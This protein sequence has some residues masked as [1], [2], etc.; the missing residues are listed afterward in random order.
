MLHKRLS[1][2]WLITP[3][4]ARLYITFVCIHILLSSNVCSSSDGLEAGFLFYIVF[5]DLSEGTTLTVLSWIYKKLLL[6][7]INKYGFFYPLWQ[8]VF[9]YL[10]IIC[11]LIFIDFQLFCQILPFNILL[12]YYNILFVLQYCA[13]YLFFLLQGCVSGFLR[14][15]KGMLLLGSLLWSICPQLLFLL[16]RVKSFLILLLILRTEIRWWWMNTRTRMK[17]F[18]SPRLNKRFDM[19]SGF[20]LLCFLYIKE[21]I[22][23]SFS[24]FCRHTR[25]GFRVISRK[26]VNN[27][28]LSLILMVFILV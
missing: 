21:Y 28:Y 15:M 1:L 13:Y 26:Q 23:C 6:Q 11:Y 14:R 24:F 10:L 27:D 16:A 25:M 19:N 22:L 12:E 17:N 3:Y 8:N 4:V 7:Y 18:R 20:V 5:W 9:I 2:L